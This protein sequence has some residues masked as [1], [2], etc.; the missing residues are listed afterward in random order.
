MKKFT[1]MI[2]I[3]NILVFSCGGDSSPDEF[4]SSTNIYE[5]SDVTSVGWKMKKGFEIAE[6]PESTDAFWGYM[7]GHE[8]GIIIY[9]DSK[10]ASSLGI[11]AILKR[12]SLYML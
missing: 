6:F 7:K 4:V 10:T 8:I 1:C 9:P 2:L 3:L 11:N 12:V 5:M